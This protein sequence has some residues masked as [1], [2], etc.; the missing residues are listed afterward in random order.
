MGSSAAR[1]QD[2]ESGTGRA[3]TRARRSKPASR[4]A[5]RIR[6]SVR[7]PRV[8]RRGGFGQVR[9][10]DFPSARALPLFATCREANTKSDEHRLIGLG[11]G[12]DCGRAPYGAKPR[13]TDVRRPASEG[14]GTRPQ[15][16]INGIWYKSARR[17]TEGPGSRK[18]RDR[19]GRSPDTTRHGIPQASARERP[20]PMFP[21]FHGIRSDPA[22][23]RSS[24]AAAGWPCCSAPRRRRPP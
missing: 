22:G 2:R 8:A 17:W 19:T 24:G 1:R 16:A 6:R 4:R 18:S 13:R 7:G 12:R 14:P 3:A 10:S 11:I 23:M 15:V 9:L 5:N 21:I 20:I